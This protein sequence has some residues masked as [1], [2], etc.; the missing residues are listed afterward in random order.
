MS[1]FEKI[2]LV[3]EYLQGISEGLFNTA[4]FASLDAVPQ[5]RLTSGPL[6]PEVGNPFPRPPTVTNFEM[7][8]G[9]YQDTEGSRL[10]SN[11]LTRGKYHEYT[12]I[13]SVA[14]YLYDVTVR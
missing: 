9:H 2:G 3:E 8:P 14:S 11:S 12:T 1:D 6:N 10:M 4:Y 5:R 7:F 13:K